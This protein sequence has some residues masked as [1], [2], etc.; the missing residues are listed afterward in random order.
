MPSIYSQCFI[1]LRL[2][3][4]DG[5]ANTAQEMNAMNIPIIHNHSSFG[6]KWNNLNDIIYHVNHEF[7]KYKNKIF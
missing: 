5:N 7:L 2:T 3:N 1:G 4:K 6:L